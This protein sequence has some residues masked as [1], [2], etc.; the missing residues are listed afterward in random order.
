L[1]QGRRNGRRE[2][3][4]L[5]ARNLR[6][7][8]PFGPT[9]RQALATSTSPDALK[10][11][12]KAWL[13]KTRN[14]CVDVDCLRQTHEGRLKEIDSVVAAANPYLGSFVRPPFIRPE[15]IKALTESGM[16][17]SKPSPRA[18]T[19]V[20]RSDGAAVKLFA[21]E[22]TTRGVKGL[23]YVYYETRDK[24]D[25]EGIVE[26]FGYRAIG[27]TASGVDVLQTF[28]SGGGSMTFEALL[29]VSLE[30][31]KKKPDQVVLKRV[32]QINLGDRW[33]GDLNVVGN[34][35]HIGPDTGI[36]SDGQDK[37]RV[38]KVAYTRP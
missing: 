10:A 19:T 23:P 26:E 11:S 37:A 14:A 20:D 2:D 9:Y 33:D 13:T 6:P 5:V 1:P 38:I 3:D 8:S 4:L 28:E 17:D 24:D 22:A 30:Y 12:Q 36:T 25:P 7:R 21:R 27:R 15:V 32:Q 29:L 31:D 34:E 35:I 18:L 16:S